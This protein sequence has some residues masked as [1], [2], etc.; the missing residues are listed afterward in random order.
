[1]KTFSYLFY[2]GVVF[3]LASLNACGDDGFGVQSDKVTLRVGETLTWEVKH[4]NGSCTVEV[5]N[6]AIVK[7]A[8][9]SGG[10]E[11]FA[12]DEGSTVVRL[13]DGN[14]ETVEL[15]VTSVLELKDVMWTIK[16]NDRPTVTVYAYAQD[17]NVAG[18]IWNQLEKD[19]PFSVGKRYAF[20]KEGESGDASGN[21]AAIYYQFKDGQLVAENEVGEKYTCTI[22]QRTND[23]MTTQE[24]LTEYFRSLYPN[25][26]ITDVKRK[27]T[28]TRY[29]NPL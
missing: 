27:I 1:M 22:I 23:S 18:D 11:L 16:G 20:V 9:Q 2:V 28:W 26:G 29:Y 5:A 12:M 25:A 15:L 17:A 14:R 8:V 21:M 3:V 6:P 4:A 7:V 13:T 19:L 10:L 24:D